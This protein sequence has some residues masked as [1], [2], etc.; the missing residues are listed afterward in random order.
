LSLAIGTKLGPFEIVAPLGAGGMGEVYRATDTRLK[1]EVALKVLPAS[2]AGNADRLARF[3]REAE[4]LAALNHPNIAAI[5]GL[6][7]TDLS[8]SSGQ[9]A[10]TALVMELVE[11][12]DLSHRLAR[13]AIPLDEVLAIATQIAEA[14]E[15]AHDRG[16]I[17]RDLKPANIKVRPDGVVKVLDFGLAKA[18]SPDGASATA[19]AMNSPTMTS[20]ARPPSPGLRRGDGEAGTAMGVILGTAAYM[21]PE[22]ARGLA[23]DRRAD[24]WAF[25]VVLWEMLTGTRLFDGGTVSDT[26]A[27]VLRSEPDWKALP[28][29]TPAPIRRLL[30]HLLD[31]DRRRRLDSAVAAR[32]EIEDAFTAPST[33]EAV[34]L[35]PAP[36]SRSGWSRALPWA[37]GALA[38]ALGVALW[39]PWRVAPPQQTSL[40]LTPLSFEQGG[41]TGAV[42]SPDGKAVAF[43]ARQKATDPFQV[44]VR[45]LDS[46]V[47]TQLT[48]L[49]GG[50][51][52]V[53]EWT[54]AGQIV[55]A[56]SAPLGLWSVSPVGGEP[57][58][59]AKES[60]IAGDLRLVLARPSVSRD[61]GVY[62]GLFSTADGVIGVATASPP[63]SPPKRY[64]PAP[65]ASR[66]LF[67]VASVEFS[68]DG[69][70]ILLMRNAG[71]GEEAWLL[72]YP[73]S[74]ANPPRRILQDMPAFNSTP[75]FSWMPD[76]RHVV[77]S[78]TT[79][80]APQ[81]LYMADTVSGAFAA[82]SRGTTNQTDP[83]V[84]PDGGRL[85]FL[86]SETNRDIVSVDLETA[87]VT[88]VIATQRGEQMPAWAS[89]DSALVYVTDRNGAAEIWLHKPGQLDRPLVTPRDFPPDTTRG[90]MA[91]AL[92][93][94][95]T[96][97]IYTTLFK[98][99]GTGLW[100]SAVAGGPPVRLV[101]STAE[102]DA[103]GSWSPDGNWY[104]YLSS[105]QGLVSLN[106]V[107]TTGQAEPE[108]LKADV[109]RTRTQWVPVWSPSG[110]WILHSDEGVK[111]ISP[112][113]KTTRTVSATGAVAFAFAADGRTIYGIRPAAAGQNRIELFSMSVAGGP[114]KTIGSLAQEYL[115]DA[116]Y[117]P[118][119]RLSLTPDGKSLTYGT[120][121]S[122]SNLWLMDGLTS[123]TG[124]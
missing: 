39:A 84:S 7:K 40:R 55:F 57:E 6:E 29:N 27:A 104:V 67:N 79:D 64:E 56:S 105:R 18:L 38:V 10:I 23:V 45:Y 24:L 13:G 103:S 49:A 121:R 9:A 112:D 12:E 28:D 70:Q 75:T 15:A 53:I 111:L 73:A 62:A 78:A 119:L 17:H 113:G 47:A 14:L 90:F 16:I 88:P 101:K 26:L 74:A 51:A 83:A 116:S 20:P 42:W 91:P 92:S 115:P 4:V 93:P 22:Q 71:A 120:V 102:S 32:L 124:R 66:A 48:R 106:K 86:E 80:A 21:A 68:P 108:V 63:G 109:K 31:K 87:V 19:D 76:N 110:E 25:G 43:G 50:V 100:M 61:G 11:G 65:F 44:Y 59:L 123:V 8:A 1:R 122:T 85:V 118:A 36:R 2:V 3:Q 58:P 30:R 37:A 97:V 114:E 89:R 5:Y 72:P 77:L 52:L 69:R 35:S 99:S 46:S 94:D 34:T 95:G 81:Q 98:L 107:K 54:A 82:F 33:S 117:R 41:Q 60:A 96:R